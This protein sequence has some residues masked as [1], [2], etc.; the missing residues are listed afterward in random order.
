MNLCN[1]GKGRDSHDEICFETGHC[2]LCDMRKELREEILEMQ[3]IISEF[4]KI[5]EAQS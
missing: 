4:A 3:N 1:G 2:P 5:E